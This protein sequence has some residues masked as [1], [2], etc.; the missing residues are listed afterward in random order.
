MKALQALW[1]A[2]RRRAPAHRGSGR[3]WLLLGKAPAVDFFEVETP[4]RPD[5]E[6]WN[7][8][9]FEEPVDSR[10]M[11]AQQPRYFRDGHRVHGCHLSAPLR[12]GAVLWQP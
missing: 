3:H 11:A 8:A 2:L 1:L 9:L 12:W 5:S 4:I 10:W 7:L 6:R